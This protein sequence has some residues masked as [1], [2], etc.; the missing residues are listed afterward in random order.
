MKIKWFIEILVAIFLALWFFFYQ[1]P[2]P[3]IT[4]SPLI[5]DRDPNFVQIE[6]E[7]KELHWQALGQE[8]VS[9][10]IEQMAKEK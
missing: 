5:G 6:A 2:I 3:K 4:P 7:V 8:S 10:Q 9:Q 1:P